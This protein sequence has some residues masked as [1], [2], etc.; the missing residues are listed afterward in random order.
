MNITDTTTVADI[1][2]SIPSSIRV[3][4]RHGIDFCCG[5]RQALRAV[6]VEHGL[7]FDVVRDEIEASTRERRVERDWTAAP[8]TELI[9]H[10]ITSYHDRLRAEFPRLAEMSA[11]V[12]SVHGAKAPFTSRIAD[13]ISELSADLRHHM[14]KEETVLFPAIA[15]LER[16]PRTQGAWIA[17]PIGVMEQE[18]DQAGELIAEL[19]QLTSGYVPPDWA[20]ATVRALYRGLE[21]FEADMHVHVHLENNVLFPRALEPYTTVPA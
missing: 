6:C 1:A 7:S 4:Q 15:A 3:F 8:L 17:M 18:H 16:D 19:R 9:D 14:R 21:E 5:G 20:C 11:K 10:I 13:I 12:A 2:A